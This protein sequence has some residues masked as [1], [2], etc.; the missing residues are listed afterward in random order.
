MLIVEGVE[1][2]QRWN[3]KYKK[4]KKTWEEKYHVQGYER[5]IF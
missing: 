2:K 4:R 3:G 1:K 5:K